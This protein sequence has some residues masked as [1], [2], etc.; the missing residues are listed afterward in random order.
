[1]IF[2]RFG[3][4]SWLPFF[5]KINTKGHNELKGFHIFATSEELRCLYVCHLKGHNMKFNHYNPNMSN[6]YCSI[7]FT[8]KHTKN[9]TIHISQLIYSCIFLRSNKT[10]ISVAQANK[11]NWDH[12]NQ[13]LPKTQAGKTPRATCPPKE[14]NCYVWR[15][16]KYI[17]PLFY[18]FLGI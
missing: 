15:F 14:Q 3:S 16:Q 18:N 13:H 4:P 12:S 8:N 9:N 7:L 10:G 6:L 11:Q 1:M 17:K 5:T 2:N